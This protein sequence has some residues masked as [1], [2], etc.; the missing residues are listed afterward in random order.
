MLSLDAHAP[1]SLVPL[2]AGIL[3]VVIETGIVALHEARARGV[4]AFARSPSALLPSGR[5]RPLTAEL[6]SHL[7]ER[8][9]P[10]P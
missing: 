10:P 9:A 3:A 4:S 8:W 5:M 7:S 1:T 6:G 2:Y